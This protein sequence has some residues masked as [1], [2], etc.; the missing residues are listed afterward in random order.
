MQLDATL[1]PTHLSTPSP[2]SSLDLNHGSDPGPE[3]PEPLELDPPLVPESPAR[4]PSPEEEEEEDEEAGDEGCPEASA[5]PEADGEEAAPL[6]TSI[7]GKHRG[8]QHSPPP[9]T[10]VTS[11]CPLPAA[12]T[13]RRRIATE[14]EVRFPLQHG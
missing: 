9:R 13:P 2:D 6:S 4:S 8:P 3:E 1:L 7:S 12:E 10:M 11:T 14:E 5:A